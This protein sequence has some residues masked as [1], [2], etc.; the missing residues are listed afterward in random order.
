MFGLS[1]NRGFKHAAP[2]GQDRA[3]RCGRE[4][5]SAAP[6]GQELA[7]GFG[8]ERAIGGCRPVTF[9]PSQ[10]AACDI[11]S[12]NSF[13]TKG[14][15]TRLTALL[16]VMF[17]FVLLVAGTCA[18]PQVALAARV[19][20][21]APAATDPYEDACEA[22][23]PEGVFL[24]DVAMEGGSGRAEVASP[25]EFEVSGGRSVAKIVW[26]SP[27][28]DYMVVNGKL[29][30]PVNKSG[31]SAFIIPVTVFDEPVEVLADTTA[32]GDPHEI[33][34]TLTFDSQ[35]VTTKDGTPVEVGSAD[36]GDG[37]GA[38]AGVSAESSASSEGASDESASAS[39]DSAASA[40]AA[41]AS[42]ESGSA[43]S[44]A[45]T[46]A[47]SASASSASSAADQSANSASSA[48]TNQSIGLSVPWIIFIIC[49]VL[50]AAIIGV[51]IGILRCY[52]N[53]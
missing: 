8:Q 53:Q 27:Y 10:R 28:Y 13:A 31:N 7:A 42:A 48:A 30:K 45:S 44:V 39:S 6:V 2:V 35:S 43:G 37:D 47:S 25:A 40:S 38:N 49:A 9:P 18:L 52:R 51:T 3:A 22:D 20:D 33:D 41:S 4:R 32:M 34:Y 21:T 26:S 29:Y 15:A 14:V 16:A 17:A 36:A 11:V 46:S 12:E 5:A 24:I 1:S 50:S 23:Y 19:G